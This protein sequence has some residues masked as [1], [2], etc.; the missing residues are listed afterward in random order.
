MSYRWLL[1]MMILCLLVAALLRLP[2][3]AEAPPGMH[4]DEA[5]DGVLAADI[6]LRGERPIFITSY[7]GKEVL[8]FY[9]A[10][11]L[12]RLAGSS[13][14]TLRLT[15]AYLALLTLAATCWLALEMTRNRRVAPL[16]VALLAVSFWH[17]LMS[18]FG[19]RSISQP[20]LQ[21]L[22]VAALLRGL[23]RPAWPWLA[24]AG[25]L[26][27]LT[28]YTYLA[29]RVFPIPLVLAA[30]PLLGHRP[31][32]AQLALVVGLAL[33]ALSPLLVFFATHPESFWVRIGQVRPAGDGLATVADSYLKSL[34]M[35]F[36]VG[37]P[38][39]R[40]NLPGRPLFNWF[41][42][43]L[44]VTGWLF[45]L[46]Q[47][48]RLRHDWQRTAA[49][50]LLLIP[51]FMLLP[52]ALAV[53]EIVPSNLRAIGLL[54]FIYLLPAIGFNLLLESV[55]K[56]FH[57]WQ[58]IIGSRA[59]RLTAL[60][61]SPWVVPAVASLVLLVGAPFTARDY[62]QRWAT[63][64]DVFYESD[65]DLAAVARFLDGRETAGQSIYVAARHYRH[66]T[67]AFLSEKYEQVRWLPGSQA[68]VVPAEGPALYVFPYNSPAPAWAK[69]I[70]LPAEVIEGP[71]G[72]DGQ[73]AF[74]AY[75][76]AQPLP[77]AAP[78]PVNVNFDNLVT[79]LG[80]EMESAPA[81]EI[82]PLTLYWRV[83]GRPPA[84]FTPFVHLEDEWRY[85]WSQV[86]TFA[87]PTEQW[88]EG[89]TIVQRVEVPVRPGTPPGAYQLRLGLFD[90]ASGRQVPH[91]DSAGRYAGNAFTIYDVPVLAGKLPGQPPEP[92]V[93]VNRPAGP[94]LELLG[95]E[96]AGERVPT[97]ADLWL[98][99]WWQATAP[100]PPMTTRL[101]LLRPDNTGII[102]ANA[103][104]VHGSYPFAE[105]TTPQF[106]IDH[107]S[108]KIP[109]SLPPGDYRLSLRLLDGADETLLTADLGPLTVEAT[110]RLFTPPQL[111][112]PL[113]ATFGNEIALLGYD[114]AMTAPRQ[115]TLS[116]VWQALTQ[117][118]ADYTV[119]VHVL[120][121]YGV[122]CLWQQDLMPQQGAYPTGRWL[123]EEVVVDNYTITLPPDVPAG[124]YAV[125]VG[126]YLADTGQRLL[127][128]IP[129]LR[130][131]DALVLRPLMVE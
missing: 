31:R 1:A 131:K 53:G 89:E 70:L 46:S 111:Q 52:T 63:R 122:C 61:Q 51:P 101:E 112:Y 108:P 125:E 107:L 34:G 49:L 118:T 56:Q 81:G 29:A 92:P 21:A 74:L 2:A 62:F 64:A 96:R 25:V 24:A 68:V 120:D 66:P 91:L 38:Y 100:L 69:A 109:A 67:L 105:W 116:L 22:T 93:A 14:F 73:P 127:I 8:F 83:D 58:A 76:A 36:I 55:Q 16:A 119:F 84:G 117:P 13:V 44:L 71:P 26:L 103:Q 37:D 82:L 42:G 50:L 3:L 128:V 35:L 86:E 18:R 39:W 27:G 10:G 7:T 124:P 15:S 110:Q 90:P 45:S 115:Y 23:R 60:F 20:L 130:A 106:V 54:P 88:V 80:Y 57:D 87:Y 9:L 5:A 19:F 48:P 11:A 94:D 97:G 28:G 72:P 40:F 85:R 75:Q 98:A 6:G 102:L 78:N 99:L 126:L 32:R 77:V 47:W 129:G 59:Q 30:L 95:Y 114:L 104:P 79:L 17:L 12:A 123:S 43:G 113:M 65:A 33:L 41:W 4:Y 121:Q